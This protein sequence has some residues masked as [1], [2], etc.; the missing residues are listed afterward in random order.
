[1]SVAEVLGRSDV[2]ER[3]LRVVQYHVC[4]LCNL[5]SYMYLPAI[6][7]DLSCRAKTEARMIGGWQVDSDSYS[8]LVL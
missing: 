7:L 2:A 6:C 1:M 5:P 4:N 8:D 3:R